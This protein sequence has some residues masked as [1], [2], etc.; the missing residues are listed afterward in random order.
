VIAP[1]LELRGVHCEADGTE[2][3]RGVAHEVDEGRIHVLMGPNGAG[4]STLAALVM[5]SPG[6]QLTAGQV[7]LRGE[8]LAGRS[9]DERARRGI[10]LAFQYPEAIPGVSITQFLRQAMA[11]RTGTEDLSVLEVRLALDEWMD[12]LGMDRAFANRHHNEGFSGGERKRNEVLQLALLEPELAILDETDSGLDIDALRTVASG[13]R[14]VRGRRP[15]MGV[16]V[17]TH[18]ATLLKELVP[19]VVHVMLD[20]RIVAQG[21]PELA[22]EIEAHGYDAIRAGVR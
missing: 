10:F 1:L 21:G 9:S 6:Y 11:A 15:E 2:I 12:R 13:V 17:V 16:L 3:L 20:G 4:K 19:D 7:L 14:T 5:G 18:Y 22:D 8:D